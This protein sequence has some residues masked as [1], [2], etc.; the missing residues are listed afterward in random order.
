MP[1]FL[2]RVLSA[3]L[4]ISKDTALQ[5]LG[6]FGL[7]FVSGM[8]LTFIS[9][10]TSNSFRQFLFPRFGLYLFGVIGVPLHELCH[11]VFAKV[12]FHDIESIKWFDPK[13]SGG[14][15][16]TV[17]HYYNERNL[18]HRIGLFFIGLGP[19][20]LAPLILFLGYRFLVPEAVT[21]SS[22]YP[23]K[24][25][26]VAL[27]FGKSLMASQ[28]WN[29]LGFYAFL[30]LAVCLTSQ[31]ELS[32]DDLKI[33]RGG[34]LPILGV[35][36]LINSAAFGLNLNLHGK[37]TQGFHAVLS[38]WTACFVTAVVISLINLLFC[39]AFLSLFNRLCGRPSIN[40]FQN[41]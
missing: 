5:F 6:L 22:L 13:G 34:V 41:T 17:V 32:P 30:Y 8:A 14:S 40:P 35:L 37:L 39:V 24:G 31:M 15:Y 18:Y 26:D 12:F 28:N 9:K 4:I 1:H 25:F 11:A 3:V 16:G 36:L 10:W 19:V 29:S 2:D 21:F 38:V 27:G 33:A 7:L 23:G 20:L